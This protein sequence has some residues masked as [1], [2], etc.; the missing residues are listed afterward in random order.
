MNPKTNGD[1][2]AM[3]AEEAKVESGIGPRAGAENA[4]PNGETRTEKKRTRGTESGTMTKRAMAGK[5]I[6]NDPG[7]AQRNGRGVRKRRTERRDD[8]GKTENRVRKEDTAEVGAKS[9]NRG[10]ARAPA[11]TLAG[12]AEAKKNLTGKKRNPTNTAEAAAAGARTVLKSHEKESAVQVGRGRAREVGVKKGATSANTRAR[13]TTATVL[14]MKRSKE[15]K[16]ILC[17]I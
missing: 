10:R 1:R 9:E 14:T 3:N 8:T 6:Q 7:S 13:T 15:S 12:E 5:R 2:E 11:K 17:D 16:T 4:R